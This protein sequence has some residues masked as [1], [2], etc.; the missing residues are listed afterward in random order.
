ML[1]A[2]L[3]NGSS[4]SY[5]YSVIDSPI[6]PITYVS[7]GDAVRFTNWLYNGQ[8]TGAE[9]NGTTETGSYTLNGSDRLRSL[10]QRPT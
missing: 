1:Q 7:W 4:G 2:L 6:K 9:G 3:Q 5:T 10:R 8:P